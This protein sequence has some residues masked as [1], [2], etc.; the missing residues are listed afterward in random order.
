MS[1][2]GV[3]GECGEPEV[4]QV[5]HGDEGWNVCGACCTIEGRVEFVSETEYEEM[6]NKQAEEGEERAS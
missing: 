1:L 2:I 3:C 5:W 6:L 4:R